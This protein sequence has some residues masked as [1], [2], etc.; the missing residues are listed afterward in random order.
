[1]RLV[2]AAAFGA[3][4]ACPRGLAAAD[5][6][7]PEPAS[8]S[9]L[10]GKWTLNSDQSEDARAKMRE[11]RGGHRSGGAGY[12]GG[13]GGF[14]GGHGGRWG[15]GADGGAMSGFFEPP[16]TLT[17]DR[18]GAEI[19]VNDGD[20]IVILHPDGRKVKSGDGRAETTAQW[21]GEELIVESRTDRGKVTTAY[22]AVPDKHQLDVTSRFEGRM[23]EPVT[24][25]RVYDA[26]VPE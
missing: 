21:R 4:L 14:G 1:V 16:E 23:G 15:G 26:A 11:A 22:L 10:A 12:G 8:A 24:A 17:I 13:H 19:A 7:G 5:K 3:A 2:L 6:A 25:R 9:A 18:N 20:R